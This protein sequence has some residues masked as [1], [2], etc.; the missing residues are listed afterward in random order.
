MITAGVTTAQEPWMP[1]AGWRL[2]P[3]DRS[4]AWQWQ[5]VPR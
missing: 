1:I 2:R 3:A 5:A 4:G